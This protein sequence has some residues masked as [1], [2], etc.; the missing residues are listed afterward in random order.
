M[1]KKINRVLF[2]VL[3]GM[4]ALS[5]VVYLHA[6][7]A[8][9]NQEV[10]EEYIIKKG[11]T[12]WDISDKFFK[13]PF[14][15]PDIWQKNDY[16]ND[17][18]LIFPG[19]KL[20]LRKILREALPM[21]EEPKEVKKKVKRR[22]PKP[23]KKIV[24]KPATPPLPEKIPVS[25]FSVLQSAGFLVEEDFGIGNIIDSPL[26]RVT[27]SKGDIVYTDIGPG[28]NAF[29]GKKFTIY[30]IAREV[31]HPITQEDMGFLINI[32]GAIEIKEFKENRS[33]A[34]ITKSYEEIARKDLI[35]EYM[36]LE[37]PMIDPSIQIE[38]KNIQGY[39]IEAKDERKSLGK[40]DIVY[41]DVGSNKGVVPGDRFSAYKT[42]TETSGTFFE[43][44]TFE[45]PKTIIGEL[46][47]IANR[48]KTATAVVT[49]S[50]QELDIGE[51]IEYK[52]TGK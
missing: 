48:R 29:I 45:Y 13:R 36:E 52:L 12:L 31:K 11:D 32:V 6:D 16:I 51:K 25:Q 47:V 49:K 38:E 9:Q 19:N 46:K 21:P 7:E 14:R 10:P 39:I 30:R 23:T 5:P 24:A 4:T 27:L 20:L 50:I 18:D 35:A 1:R 15:W 28:R 33:A 44:V 34:L 3:I 43:K 26:D 41:I 8:A 37:V 17:P 42:K 2:L 40:G 22:I